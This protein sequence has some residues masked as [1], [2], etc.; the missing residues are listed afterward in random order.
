MAKRK[1]KKNVE[2]Q[3]VPDDEE[4]QFLG[5]MTAAYVLDATGHLHPEQK[6]KLDSL[7]YEGVPKWD[8]GVEQ[9][10]GINRTFIRS[11]YALCTEIKEP[12]DGVVFILQ[13]I[14][15]PDVEAR[16]RDL[17]P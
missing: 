9:H 16:L 10:Y 8:V 2:Q 3:P 4:R 12:I 13:G 5:F 7:A 14:G 1:P 11:V 6:A 17:L 15:C